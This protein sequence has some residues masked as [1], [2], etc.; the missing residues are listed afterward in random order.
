MRPAVLIPAYNEAGKIEVIFQRMPREWLDRTIVID[1]GSTDATPDIAVRYGAHVLSTGGRRGIGFALRIGIE[2]ALAEGAEAV[3]IM[4]GNSKDDPR[5]LDRI[6]GPVLEGRADFVQ[7]SRY[8]RPAD[9]GHMPSYRLLATRLIH[10]LLWFFLTGRRMTDSTNGYRC[11]H[12]RLFLRSD[13]RWKDAW[14]EQY[15]FE[16]YLLYQAIR[17]RLRIVEVPVR[18]VYPPRKLG[19][20]K[21]APIRGWWSI[22]R[23]I[24]LLGLG[25]RS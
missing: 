11:I 6:A 4:A 14:L 18:K 19:Y 20:T 25:L 15:E 10:P 24:V 8:L 5:E 3:I 17:L 9:F 16:Y 23:P 22:L 13:V 1:D 21:I 12:H 2:H 7:G